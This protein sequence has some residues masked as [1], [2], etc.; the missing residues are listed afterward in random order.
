[1]RHEI[2]QAYGVA[3]VISKFLQRPQKQSGGN[4]L[5]HRRLI[6]ARS[7]GCGWSSRE[8]DKQTVGR[9]RWL[10]FRAEL[11][12]EE[13]TRRG[14]RIDNMPK[15]FNWDSLITA[16]FPYHCIVPLSLHCS[17]ITALFPYRFNNISPM[18]INVNYEIINH[19]SPL[20][21]SMIIINW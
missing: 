11:A 16:L 17:L 6:K 21:S 19:F 20:I 14:I 12:R 8:S 3:I 7:I 13:K 18:Y 5:I 2:R 4:Q 9:L 10:V 15:L 1:V